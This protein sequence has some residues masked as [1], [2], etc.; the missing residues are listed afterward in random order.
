MDLSKLI[1]KKIKLRCHQGYPDKNEKYTKINKIPSIL[2]LKKKYNTFSINH[3]FSDFNTPVILTKSGNYIIEIVLNYDYFTYSE[4]INYLC[5][6]IM[7]VSFETIGDVVHFNLNTEYLPYKFIIGKIVYDKTGCTVINKTGNINSKFRY[8]EFEYIG[9]KIDI[10]YKKD[11]IVEDGI[12]YT[13]KDNNFNRKCSFLQNLENSNNFTLQDSEKSNN[14][15][16]D[17][18]ILTLLR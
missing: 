9:G 1:S 16:S 12:T 11:I 8:Y 13:F 4:I 6:R 10:T 15:K 7:P 18:L 3:S 14:C 2:N 5:N 17:N